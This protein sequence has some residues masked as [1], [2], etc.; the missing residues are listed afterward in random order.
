M[1][2]HLLEAKDDLV[3]IG[4]ESSKE[5]R[6]DLGDVEVVQCKQYKAR[7]HQGN[8]AYRA[9]RLCNNSAKLCDVSK[10]IQRSLSGRV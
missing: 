4:V 6:T 5:V 2:T 1:R 3:Q 8:A 10:A 7:V 9:E